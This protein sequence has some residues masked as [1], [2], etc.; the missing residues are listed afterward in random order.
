MLC[1][2]LLPDIH[3]WLAQAGTPD[4]KVALKPLSG[5]EMDLAMAA[6]HAWGCYTELLGELFLTRD[7]P[8]GQPMLKVSLRSLCVHTFVA[9]NSVTVVAQHGACI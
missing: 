4:S 6:V 8:V 9:S 5:Q 1:Y 7:P 3:E 2:V